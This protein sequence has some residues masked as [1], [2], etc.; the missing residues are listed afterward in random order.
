MDLNIIFWKFVNKAWRKNEINTYGE[1][2][3]GV[4]VIFDLFYWAGRQL[5]DDVLVKGSD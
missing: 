2:C 3:L 4:Q 1:G 5:S